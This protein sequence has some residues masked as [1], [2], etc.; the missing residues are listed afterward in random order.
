[1]VDIQRALDNYIYELLAIETPEIRLLTL[2]PARNRDEQLRISI[3]HSELLPPPV[4]IGKNLPLDKL[5]KHYLL[6]GKPI[7]QIRP[8]RYFGMLRRNGLR[9]ATPILKSTKQTTQLNLFIKETI[10]SPSSRA[11]RMYGE[12]QLRGLPFC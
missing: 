2:L 8:R 3:H 5:R 12:M 6:I 11:C 10:L 7:G 1:M 4:R 9:G